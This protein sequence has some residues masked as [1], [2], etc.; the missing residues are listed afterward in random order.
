[1]QRYEKI[2]QIR[3][4]EN[5][6]MIEVLRYIAKKEGYFLEGNIQYKRLFNNVLKPKFIQNAIAS[7]DGRSSI[8]RRQ[9]NRLRKYRHGSFPIGICIYLHTLYEI[10]LRYQQEAD[11]TPKIDD[12]SY[13]QYILN[14]LR[15]QIEYIVNNN[16]QNGNGQNNIID[17]T[18]QNNFRTIYEQLIDLDNTCGDNQLKIYNNIW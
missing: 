17:E 8:S 11:I 7:N 1:M 2:N 10:M 13:T 3:D 9:Y 16:N 15:D 12:V 18:H 6:N 14:Y 5:K 4:M